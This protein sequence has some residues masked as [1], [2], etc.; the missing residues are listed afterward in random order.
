MINL[1]GDSLLDDANFERLATA[2]VHRG[3]LYTVVGSEEE[4]KA[5]SKKLRTNGYIP[6]IKKIANV[7]NVY[8][9]ADVPTVEK[10]EDNIKHLQKIAHN[11]YRSFTAGVYDYDFDDG[12]IWKVQTVNGKQC[13]V[14]VVDDIDENKVIRQASASRPNMVTSDNFVNV[15]L[16]FYGPNKMLLNDIEHDAN[17]KTAMIRTLHNKLDNKVS[18]ILKDNRIISTDTLREGLSKVI[19]ASNANSL[20]DINDVIVKYCTQQVR[21]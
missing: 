11:V 1:S 10:T 6:T 13:L 8:Y 20:Q 16:M 4:A 12:S 14:K 7:Y 3:K 21:G 2:L 9:E 17:L 15:F 5:V 19:T 18:Q